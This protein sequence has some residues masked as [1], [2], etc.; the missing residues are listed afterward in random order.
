MTARLRLAATSAACAAACAL[1]ADPAAPAP[2]PDRGEALYEMRC[3]GCHSQSLHGREKRV[4]AD[5]AS[6]RAWV[7]RW[8]A[9]LRLGWDAGEVDDVAV[10]LNRRFYRYPCPPTA[11]KVVSWARSET[12]IGGEGNR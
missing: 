12:S 3:T 5:F 9:T 11:C 7:D 2:A 4:A 8:N 10:H 6:V 1:A